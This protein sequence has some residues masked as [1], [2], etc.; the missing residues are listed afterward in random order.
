M[1]ELSPMMAQYFAIKQ[2]HKDEI[3]FFRLG[4]FYE[5]FYDDAILA[6][7]E[8]EL[9]LTGRDCGQPERAPMCGVP[10]HSYESYVARLIAKGYK[11]AICEQMEDPA[12]AK[13]LVKRDVIR[14]IT[15]GTVIESSMLQDDKNNY[16]CSIYLEGD[17]AGICFAD[18]STGQTYA[19]QLGGASVSGQIITE[20]CR[21]TPS[22]VL[23]NEATLSLKEVTAYIKQHMACAVELMENEAYAGAQD[24]LQAQFGDEGWPSGGLAQDGPAG[25]AVAGLLAYL[26]RTQKH[27]VERLKTVV[28]YAEAQYMQLS[29]VTRA[30]LELTQT[31][32][33][34][35]KRG[36]L[37][38]VL[39]KTQT[40]M[41]KRLLRS[42]LEQPL[43]S[44]PAINDRLDCVQALF[45]DSVQR[46]EV[47]ETLS[48]IFDMERL[49]TRTVYGSATPKEVY[50]LAAT[51]GQLPGLRQLAEGLGCPQL[52][53]VAVQIDPLTDIHDRIVAAIDEE[54]P[55]TLKDGGVIRKGF[56][57]EVDELRDIVHGG[58]GFLSQMEAKLK[59]ETGIRTLKV[60]FNRVF[61]YYIEVSKSFTGQVPANF[62]RKQTLANAERYITEDLKNLENKILGA[63]ERLL[64]LERKLFEELLFDLSAQLSRIQATA[65][66]VARLDVFAALAQVAA[67][68]NYVRPTVDEG[69]ELLIR[70]GRHPVI[71]RMLKGSLFVPNDTTL[72][73]GENNLL[74]I[75]GPNMAGKSTYMRQNA[76]IALMAQIGSFVPA[77]ECRVGVVDAIFTRVGASDD[78]AAGQSTF[79]V[80]MTEVAQILEYATRK[81]LV[82]LDEIGRGTSTFD[83]MSIARAVV[84][85]IAGKIGCKTLFATHYHEL[86][87][88]EEQLP[89]VKNYNI[90][91][92]KRGDDITFL[93]RIVRGPADDS[94]GIQVAKLAG[95]PDEVTERAKQVLKTLDAASQADRRVTQLDFEALEAMN[96]PAAPSEMMDKLNALDVE[97]L[98]PIEALNFLYELKKT[99]GN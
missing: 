25:L 55:S 71:E 46:A 16:I 82:I 3:L 99:L 54:A 63:S 48:H 35:E 65:G 61:G 17:K 76:L 9:T 27:G 53:A 93:R 34:R 70:E 41:G 68:N 45:G 1:A 24:T 43:V 37:L 31:M 92:K 74:I 13:G 10:F 4:D 81:S 39:D 89:G 57:P 64:A 26:G 52:K 49:M 95:L 98:T 21:Y 47:I 90:A 96:S 23:F 78:L 29:P 79:M 33:G 60:G 40:A 18:V 56:S 6:S 28:S 69:S 77:K 20:L 36:T 11:V 88:L 91:V 59:E 30:N 14:V 22:E 51:C 38:W 62:V 84:E 83:G 72:D 97:T 94:Y 12:L 86:T 2:Q 44:A 66:A 19:T 87:E 5:M 85:H 32:R 80:E 75:T 50:A 42:W 8:L 58:R 73:C 15:P 7:K 67:D